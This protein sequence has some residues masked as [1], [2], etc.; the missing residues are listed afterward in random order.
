MRQAIQ[1]LESAGFHIAAQADGHTKMVKVLEDEG[2]RT[3]T[4]LVPH[5]ALEDEY[6]AIGSLNSILEQTGMSRSEFEGLTD[7]VEQIPQPW[8]EPRLISL[9]DRD[10]ESP[11]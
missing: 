6:L 4:V 10:T 3:M 1:R 8:Y 2:L 11:R 9:V 7:A 5:P